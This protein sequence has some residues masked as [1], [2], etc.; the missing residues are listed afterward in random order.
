MILDIKIRNL[1]SI[2]EEVTIDF[3]AGEI[4][5]EILDELEDNYVSV[6]EDKILKSLGI[7]GPNASGKS[8][9]IKAISF[10]NYVILQS[11]TFNPGYVFEHEPFKLDEASINGPSYFS[12]SFL[13]DEIKYA[14]SFLFNK[15]GILKE[16]LYY[17][18][19]KEQKLIYSRVESNNPDREKNYL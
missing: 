18:P 13:L 12:I 2:N 15:E 3:Q 4:K 10:G 7:F 17:Y 9:I 1:Y 14:Y 16:S 6:G 8:N 19:N 5:S 11:H